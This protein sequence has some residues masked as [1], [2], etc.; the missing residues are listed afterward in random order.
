[1]S[2]A[3]KERLSWRS[4]IVGIVRSRG[5]TEC[6]VRRAARAKGMNGRVSEGFWTTDGPE[7]FPR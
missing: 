2:V 4:A 6:D 5:V 1:M 7:D 3:N